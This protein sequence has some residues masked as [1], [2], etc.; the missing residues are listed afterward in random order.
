MAWTVIVPDNIGKVI[1]TIS[2]ETL[3]DKILDKLDDIEEDPYSHLHKL[4]KYDLY[5]FRVDGYRGIVTIKN[6]KLIIQILRLVLRSNST[7]KGL[8]K[9]VGGIK[10]K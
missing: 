3:R 9:L 8:D 7:Y 2:D 5:K 6:H 1:D 4:R 10:R